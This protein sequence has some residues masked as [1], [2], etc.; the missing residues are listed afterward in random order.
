MS[1]HDEGLDFTSRL[2]RTRPP[3]HDAYA[4]WIGECECPRCCPVALPEPDED[5]IAGDDQI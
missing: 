1:N 2:A 4:A 5:D 3:S